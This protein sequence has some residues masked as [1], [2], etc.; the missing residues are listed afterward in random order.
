MKLIV[1][2]GNPGERYQNT[3]HNI[4]FMV[5]DHLV[6][7]LGDRVQ[8]TGYSWSQS[9]KFQAEILKL[10][11]TLSPNPQ[12]LILAKPQT[13]MNLSGEAVKAIANFYKIKPEDIIVIHDELDLLLGHVKVKQGG[14]F[15]GHHGVES[16]MNE[17]GADQFIRVRLG[18]GNAQSHS[19]E[20]KRNSFPAEKYVLEEFLPSEVHQ[21]KTLV[22]KGVEAVKAIL[23][24]G[25]DKAQSQYN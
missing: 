14:G 10:D 18:I 2:L 21:V 24:K 9:D 20:A 1:G 15:G 6:H 8:G 12:T 11:Y 3:R 16:V 5:M 22:K 25:L 17:L 4:G 19:G 7:K 23:D 13:S